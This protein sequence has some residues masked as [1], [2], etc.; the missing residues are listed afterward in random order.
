MKRVHL[1]AIALVLAVSTSAWAGDGQYP[2]DAG[3][4]QA[5]SKTRSQV[6]AELHEAQRLGLVSSGDNDFSYFQVGAQNGD[7]AIAGDDSRVLRAKIRA[8]TREEEKLGL[9]NLG[10]GNPPIATAQQEQLISV[11]GE[12][13]ASQARVAQQRT[14]ARPTN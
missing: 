2:T 5:S 11:A 9:L 3:Y 7:T 8:E 6:I 10:D 12:Q 4:G 13:A 14:V 1:S